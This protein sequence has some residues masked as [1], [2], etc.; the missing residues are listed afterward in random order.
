MAYYDKIAKRWN[1]ITG[2]KGGV[3]KELV[4]NDILIEKFP[5]IANI[6]ILEL[7][8]GNGYFLPLALRRFSGQVPA[9]ITVTDQSVQLLEIAKRNFK[10]NNAVYQMLDVSKPFPFKNDEFDLIIATMIFNEINAY[11]FKNALKE[12]C[13]VLSSP[14]TLLIT[15]T[16]PDFITGLQNQGLLKPLQQEFF[17]MPSSG[18]LR[19]PVVVRPLENYR[20]S[21]QEAG[22]QFTETEVHPTDKVL[23]IKQGLRHSAKSPIALVFNCKKH[24]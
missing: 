22:F 19:L 6:S 12:C 21:L 10:I 15:V 5:A 3:F 14:G 9:K 17:T 11:T 7:G 8:A 13:R 18:D 23:N 4:L 2:Y 20:I 1:E 16:H 24:G